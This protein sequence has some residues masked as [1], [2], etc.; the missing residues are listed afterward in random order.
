MAILPFDKGCTIADLVNIHHL[1]HKFFFLFG[2]R[3]TKEYF[4][5]LILGIILILRMVSRI[6][7]T[8]LNNQEKDIGHCMII[9]NGDLG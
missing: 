2:R 3:A 1:S 5:T 4:L 7:S 6:I 8:T 9:A